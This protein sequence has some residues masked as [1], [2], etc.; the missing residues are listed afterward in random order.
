MK[1]YKS[2]FIMPLLIIVIVVIALVGGVAYY[3]AQKTKPTN[4]PQATAPT[5]T[6]TVM[7]NSQAQPITTL[8]ILGGPGDEEIIQNTIIAFLQDS[9]NVVTYQDAQNVLLKYNT[10]SAIQK[11]QQAQTTPTLQLFL[12]KVYKNMPDP[13]TMQ[14]TSTNLTTDSATTT[15][16]YLKSPVITQNGKPIVTNQKKYLIVNLKSESGQWRI[17]KISFVIK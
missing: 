7:G 10:Q 14:Y 15:Y 3:A 12:V 13:A 17:D 8:P 4:E 16:T 1:N 11:K 9:R 6:Q 5:S 2:G